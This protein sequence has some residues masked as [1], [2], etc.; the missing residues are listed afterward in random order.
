MHVI[1]ALVRQRKADLW[2]SLASHPRL[3]GE[4]QANEDLHMHT[5]GKKT[6]RDEA[7]Y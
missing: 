5:F 2:V 4:L 1:L 3:K 6:F 7:A